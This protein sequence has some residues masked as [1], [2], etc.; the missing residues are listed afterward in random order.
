MK[1]YHQRTKRNGQRREM[2]RIKIGTLNIMTLNTTASE[3][4]GIMNEENIDI[5]CCFSGCFSYTG[6]R[7]QSLGAHPSAGH[8]EDRL[9]VG[10]SG[11]GVRTSTTP[12][13][14]RPRPGVLRHSPQPPPPTSLPQRGNSAVRTMSVGSHKNANLLRCRKF[15]RQPPASTSRIWTRLSTE[16]EDYIGLVPGMGRRRHQPVRVSLTVISP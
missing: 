11:R 4:L 9:R 14:M 10:Q 15:A 5:L 1:W 12:W 13:T 2:D 7:L 16:V 6:R 8:E 3:I